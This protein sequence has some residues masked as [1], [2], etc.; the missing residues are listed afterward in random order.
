MDTDQFERTH[1]P[2]VYYVIR[3]IGRLFIPLAMR[4]KI[5]PNSVTIASLVALLTAM[6][7]F[8]I[9]G[10]IFAVLGAIMIHI[11]HVL[12]TIDGDLA[13]HAKL[14]TRKGEYLDAI[15]GYLL[16]GLLLFSIG[17]GLAIKPDK[18]SMMINRSIHILPCMYITI[19]LWSGLAFVM[20]RLINL[21]Y[22]FLFNL[23]LRNTQAKTLQMTSCF[24]D[25]LTPLLM[26]GAIT[27]TLS[28]VLLL[29]S[30]YYSA[31]FFYTLCKSLQSW[32]HLD[33]ELEY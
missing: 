20:V 17:I 28:I 11:E 24:E 21:R 27:K 7:F 4:L 25:M 6:I 15:G 8:S 14:T 9:G 18:L 30:L 19:G 3:P 32:K 23:S 5:K 26:L 29:Y 10:I 2:Y 33:E 31:K 12:D 22:R 13:R 16:G 1:F